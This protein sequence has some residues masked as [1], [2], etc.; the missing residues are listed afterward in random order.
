MPTIH[1]TTFRTIVEHLA[2]VAAHSSQNKMGAKNLALIFG[3]TLFGEDELPK[4]GDLANYMPGKDTVAEDLIT[5]APL[6]FGEGAFDAPVLPAGTALSRAG[7]MSYV[8]KNDRAGS[9]HTRAKLGSRHSSTG[10]GISLARTPSVE[11]EQLSL[12]GPG[13]QES[14]VGEQLPPFQVEESGSPQEAPLP[15]ESPV[16]LG[17]E[18]IDPQREPAEDNLIASPGIGSPVANG[19]SPV[20]RL[21]PGALPPTNQSP[22][23]A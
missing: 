15:E 14:H 13:M 8:P 17:Q 2:R 19:S 22:T 9:A 12:P 4:N 5:Y 3:N 7:S 23:S 11:S 10:T 16:T 20:S 18:Q 6:L 1:Q 21:P